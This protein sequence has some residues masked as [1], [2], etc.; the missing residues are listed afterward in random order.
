V[1]INKTP[2]I[3]PARTGLRTI[4]RSFTARPL[5]RFT[6]TGDQPTADDFRVSISWG[7]RSSLTAGSAAGSVVANPDG[8]FSVLGSHTYRRP[9]LYRITISI[10]LPATGA[11]RHISSILRVR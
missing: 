11:V 4:S 6:V 5:A 2:A 10:S 3:I 8:S 7:D 1:L 9:G